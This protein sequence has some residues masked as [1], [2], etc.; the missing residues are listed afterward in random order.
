M[1]YI[2]AS[3]LAAVLLID[4][5]CV[6]MSLRKAVICDLDG[7]LLDTLDD[8]AD[9]M[10]AVLARLGLPEH[11]RDQY[12]YFVGDGL[13]TLSRRVLPEEQRTSEMIRRVSDS[14]LAEYND[15]WAMQTHPYEGVMQLLTALSGHGYILNV[16][17]NKPEEFTR[18]MVNHFL[19]GLPWAQIRGA[20]SGVPR[21]PDPAGALAIAKEL[22][23]EPAQ[24]LYLGDT[25]TDMMTANAAGMY[26]VGVL[27]GFRAR[28]ELEE[29]G[30]KTLLAHPLDLCTVLDQISPRTVT[31]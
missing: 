17:S 18:R 20:R 16:L 15:R 27:W 6:A 9:S 14:M 26:P 23:L 25:N 7:T 4:E 30:A 21:K 19:S 11:L 10:N 29:S 22:D 3:P 13:E 5:R 24:F 1:G 8:L 2:A 31:P 28:K 12:R